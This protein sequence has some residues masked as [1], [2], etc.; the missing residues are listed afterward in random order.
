MFR[1]CSTTIYHIHAACMPIVILLICGGMLRIAEAQ[2]ALPSPST[3]Q[4]PDSGANLARFFTSKTPYEFW[5]SCLIV[6]LGLAIIGALILALRQVR[7][8]RPED[9][10]RPIIVVAV[11]TGTL[12]LVTVGYTNEQIA[13]AFGLFGTIVGYMLGRLTQAPMR[14]SSPSEQPQR[15]PPQL[16]GTTVLSQAKDGAQ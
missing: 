4:N 1:R 10:S 8:A 2:D 6:L 3:F 5:L 13:P 11:I 14:T 7:D 15:S 16:D 9:F 12:I